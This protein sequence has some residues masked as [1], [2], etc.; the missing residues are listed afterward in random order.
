MTGFKFPD[1]DSIP[2]TLGTRLADKLGEINFFDTIWEKEKLHLSSVFSSEELSRIF[3]LEKF[4]EILTSGSLMSPHLDIVRNGKKGPAPFRMS[5]SPATNVSHV[6]QA[7]EDGCTLR[8]AHIENYIPSLSRL[9]RSLEDALYIPLRANLY[10]TPP[11]SQ[12][13][14]PHYD[15]DDIFV[16]QVLGEK[17]WYLHPTYTEQVALPNESF[18]FDPMKHKP[19]GKANQIKLCTGDLLYLPRG[20]MHE[21]RTDT[22]V[23]I[24]ITLA[25]IGATLGQFIEQLFRRL[26]IL[27]PGLRRT[28]GF[29]P[30]IGPDASQLEALE[31]E[32]RQ[33]L[34]RATDSNILSSGVSAMRQYLSEHRNPDL[35]G[36]IVQ[37]LNN[38]FAR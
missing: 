10:M 2:H 28:V 20:F 22:G 37:G 5:P 21:A 16:I 18:P 29:D 11:F 24:H 9:C 34:E 17:R 14:P 15:L 27:E 1:E 6:L 35:G 38:G 8:V 19:T 12:G 7:L 32:I 23:S 26:A 4:D 13:F 30:H 3:P 25:A 31:S 36:K 33:Y